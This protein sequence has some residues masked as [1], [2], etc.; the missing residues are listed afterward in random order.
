MLNI[1]VQLLSMQI[2]VNTAITSIQNLSKKNTKI[3]TIYQG[4][5]RISL[6]DE[7]THGDSDDD[8]NDNNDNDDNDIS[9]DT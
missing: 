1:D 9:K 6:S 8:N 7:E 3:T 2:A 4:G 5:V